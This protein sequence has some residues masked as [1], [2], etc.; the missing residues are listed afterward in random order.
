M[1]GI[2]GL[3][4]TVGELHHLNVGFGDASVIVT[5]SAAFLIDCHKIEEYARVLPKRIRGIFITHQHRD[6]AEQQKRGGGS[7]SHVPVKKI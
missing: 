3:G 2:A 1:T 5:E 4:L 7:R 6:Q